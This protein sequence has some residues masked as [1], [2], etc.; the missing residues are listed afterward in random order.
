MYETEDG[1]AGTDASDLDELLGQDDGHEGFVAERVVHAVCGGCEG[2]VFFFAYDLGG[3]DHYVE[4]RCVACGNRYVMLDASYAAPAEEPFIAN[5][6]C[7]R[8][9][10]EIA[11]G[12]SQ[13]D[14]GEV[15]YVSIALRCIAD[16]LMYI[17]SDWLV[18]Q[19]PSAYLLTQV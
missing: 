15:E 11:V 2:K 12:F 16:G 3:G 6:T 7:C 13:D 14:T 18:S 9:E 5:C 8:E 17:H 4:R 10:F 19:S 1:P